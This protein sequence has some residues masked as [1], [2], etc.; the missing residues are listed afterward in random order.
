MPELPDITVYIEAL[1]K[2]ILGQ[3]L[4]KVRIVSPFLLRS[5]EPPVASA[6]G[7]KVVELRRMGK[8]ICIGLGDGT[9]G[10]EKQEGPTQ[11]S[12]P[13]ETAGNEPA[14]IWLVLHLMIAG[15]L[16]WGAKGKKLSK[17]HLAAFDFENGSLL[18]TEAGS[19]KRASLHLARGEAGLAEFDRG[20]LEILD[21]TLEQF[22]KILTSENHTLKRALTDPEWFSG[23]GNAY[24]DEILWEAK[25]SP[26][27]QT[28]KM[29]EEEIARL[30]EAA[31]KS[32]AEWT[33]RLRA[34]TGEKFPEG[35]T[36]FRPEMA[37][38]GK[39]K[40]ACPRC[41]GSVQRIKY[42]SNETNYCPTCQTGGKLL[43]DRAFSRLLREDWPKTPEELELRLGQAK[44]KIAK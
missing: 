13:T 4:E 7:K 16:H 24:S 40:Q 12:A 20:G 39:Y 44:R 32:L 21:A 38:H 29:K 22:S 19:Q 17:Q 14:E 3:R 6:A 41:G 11:K 34:E 15:R 9:A 33:D 2:R 42:A 30:F 35:V 27:L 10:K 5:V 36:A 26:L 43:A 28:H 23:I 31:R 37:V 25:L 1:E 18:W 8:R